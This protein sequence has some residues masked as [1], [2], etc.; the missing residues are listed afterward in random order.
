MTLDIHIV[1]H[2]HWDRE[3]YLTREQYRLRLMGL[4]DRVLDRL[5]EN[6]RFTH[7]HL[8]GQTIVIEDY[9]EV[10]PDQE[11]RIRSHITAGRLLVGP[12]YVMPDMHLVSGE[13]LVRNLALGHRIAER[14]GGV[15]GAGYMPDPFGHVAQMPQI[16]AGFSL[17]SAILWRGFGGERAEYVWRAPDGSEVLLLHLPPEGYG[18]ALWLPLRP[19]AEMRAL[20]A[21]LVAREAARSSTSVVLL[22]AGVDHVEPHPQLLDLPALLREASG[23]DA[24]ISTL[25]A[26][27]AAVRAG[28]DHS[29]RDGAP[30]RLEVI[31]GELRGGEEYS[32]LLPGVL[33][34][35]TYLKREN[36][37]TQALLERVA[38]PLTAVAWMLG[39]EHPTGLLDYAWR[40]LLQNHPHDSIC[41]CSVDEVHDENMTRFARVSQAA[42]AVAT[43]ALESIARRAKA[44]PAG[45]MAGLLVS[46]APYGGVVEGHVDVPFACAE[47]GRRFDPALFETRVDLFSEPALVSVRDASGSTIPFQILDHE[48]ALIHAM[49]RYEPPLALHARRLR[50]A[51]FLPRV[52]ALT[53][54]R[55][56]FVMGRRLEIPPAMP[57]QIQPVVAG[58]AWMDNG[59]I[60]L[61]ARTDGAFDLHDHRDD[62]RYAGALAM[63]DEGDVGDE[64][65]FSPPAEQRV[66]TNAEIRNWRIKAVDPGPLVASLEATFD[67]PLPPRA[68]SDR[69]R[70]EAGDAPLPVRIKVSMTAGSSQV[71]VRVHLENRATD[72]R[73]RLRFPTGARQVETTRADTAFAVME[74]PAR[75]PQP[76]VML[77]EM[78]VSAVPAHSV[79][80]AGDAA[81]GVSVWTEGL[82]ECEVVEAPGGPA[83]AVTL[84]RCVGFLSRDDLATR[85]GHAGPGLPTPGAQCLGLHEFRLAFE[86]RSAPPSV[87]ALLAASSSFLAPPRLIAPAG[88]IEGAG[89]PVLSA[90]KKCGERESL[91]VRIFNTR[92]EATPL[93]LAAFRPLREAYRLD[94]REKRLKALDVDVRDGAVRLDVRPYGIE[95]IELVFS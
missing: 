60:R 84:L 39:D 64:Y 94:L 44:P 86:P 49:S 70:R 58:E 34:A 28:L 17:D 30:V 53:P 48:D 50:L 73:L 10:R 36:V 57:A 88:P 66:V 55:V 13:S 16:L 37:R 69:G 83:L 8:D 1:S 87:A 91:V 20:G 9:L 7:F 81:S 59:I 72:H 65:N 95:T 92:S 23:E 89:A 54:T 33:S 5:E 22:M 12:W 82:H 35:R 78:P 26:Y 62:R 24:R 31:E 85:R 43:Q 6:P 45:S 74:R 19:P 38:E 47:P 77:Q 25:P 76:K 21:S 51:I 75:R 40:T 29:G 71:S 93:R 4:I 27:V 15:M 63:W 46:A 67:L 68:S 52:A 14:F 79:I 32:N 11:E 18:N 61:E 90:L 41:G 3:W 80:D 2:T 56:E 42:E